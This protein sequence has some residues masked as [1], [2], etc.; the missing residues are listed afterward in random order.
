MYVHP[1]APRVMRPVKELKGFAKV[2]LKPGEKREL[3]VS[4]GAGAFSDYENGGW[5][6][7]PG[8]YEVEVGSS[9]RD[10]RLRGVVKE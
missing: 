9:S 8:E 1:V 10:I 4:L 5:V 3:S 7:E 6:V 2:W